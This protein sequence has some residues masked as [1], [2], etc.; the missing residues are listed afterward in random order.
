M[1]SA[2]SADAHTFFGQGV[3]AADTSMFQQLFAIMAQQNQTF[4]SAIQAQMQQT[5]MQMQ[6]AQAQFEQ[7]MLQQGGRNRKTEP[8]SYEGKINDD[9]EL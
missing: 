6:R 4:Q 7:L 9:L 1:P 3:P 8:P 2:S 5:Q